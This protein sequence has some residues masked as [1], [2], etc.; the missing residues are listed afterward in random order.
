[1]IRNAMK[2]VAQ[3]QLAVAANAVP[4]GVYKHWKGPLYVVFATSVDEAFCV[5]LVH[6]YSIER[7]TRWTRT[8]TDWFGHSPD[9]PMT[10]RRFDFVRQAS[11]LELLT[12]LGAGAG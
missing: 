5:P 7:R 2:K 9:C 3:E 8:F 4:L 11:Q 6:Y 12:A 10:M 1:M